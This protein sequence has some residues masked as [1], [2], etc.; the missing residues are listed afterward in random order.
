MDETLKKDNILFNKQISE[1]PE[2][3]PYYLKGSSIMDILC[4]KITDL[5]VATHKIVRKSESI[6]C[7]EQLKSLADS[8]SEEVVFLLANDNNFKY[9]LNK[10]VDISVLIF[11]MSIFSRIVLQF[12][13]MKTI[14][15]DMICNSTYFEN[16]NN[17]FIEL[18][19][20]ENTIS[21]IKLQEFFINCNTLFEAID[22]QK[23]RALLNDILQYKISLSIETMSIGV[24]ELE[25]NTDN[26]DSEKMIQILKKIKNKN[27]VHY[28]VQRWPLFYETLTNYPL[29]SDITSKQV[30][31][32]P[33]IMKGS[34]DDVEHYIDVQI[35]LLRE[36]F[37]APMREGIQ[38]YKEMIKLN[39]DVKKMPNMCVYFKVKLG[40]K[41]ENNRTSFIVNFYTKEDCSIDS[42]RFMSKSMLVFS[43]DNFNTMFFALVIKMNRNFL[44]PSKRL[45][46]KPLGHNVT[47]NLN[48]SYT[49][50]ESDTFFLPYMY[51]MNVLKKLNHI[52]FPMKSYIVYGRTE[53]KTPKY[54]TC[55]SK[56]YTINGIQFDILNDNLWPD[57]KFLG[58]DS[59]QSMALKA[60]LTEEFTVIQGP[61]GTGK[62]YIGLKIARSII[63]N[64]YKTNKLKNPIIVVCYTNHALD[65]FLEGII[66]ITKHVT[67]IGGG[68]KSDVLKSHV[69][70]NTDTPL[71]L[72]HLKKS[73]VVGFTTTGA[74]KRRS[75]LLSLK[76]PI[77]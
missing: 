58:L 65:Q 31:L 13:Q 35:R 30:I 57:N 52:N 59:A 62:T 70:G 32:S 64:M 9:T 47:I 72:K 40:K 55:Q 73:Y 63:E 66:N 21:E 5:N 11:L 14:I 19:R 25:L 20:S 2:V 45:V 16:L 37:I 44:S 34:Y 75:L 36:D 54:L 51:T 60:A 33:N 28:K 23:T 71:S 29:I 18:T 68:C 48:S 12:N 77:G 49:M 39:Q 69:F 61:P 26:L 41:V 50:A 56:I 22:N 15:I 1:I 10:C 3:Q 43:N 17:S 46:I 8:E 53:P 67:R 74:A 76:P 6:L 27:C 38:A 4:D 24:E 7:F 42:K